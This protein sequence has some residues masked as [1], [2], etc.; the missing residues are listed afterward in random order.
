[1]KFLTQLLQRLNIN[2]VLVL[3]ILIMIIQNSAGFR[4][5]SLNIQ[6][7]RLNKQICIEEILPGTPPLE[8]IK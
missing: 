6:C 5:V 1:M 2:K 3:I 7:E 8:V 4:L